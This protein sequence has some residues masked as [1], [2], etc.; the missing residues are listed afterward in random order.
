MATDEAYLKS[1]ADAMPEMDGTSRSSAD[2]ESF[3][4]SCR[5]PGSSPR[6]SAALQGLKTTVSWQKTS[7]W[8]AT[9]G[10]W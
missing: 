2:L 7:K 1:C 8:V 10:M 9:N 3:V 4:P 6:G 5:T